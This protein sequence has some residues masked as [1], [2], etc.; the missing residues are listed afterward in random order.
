MKS[1]TII[2]IL[3]I[4]FIF[5]LLMTFFILQANSLSI[6]LSSSNITYDNPRQI[7]EL[8]TLTG[9]KDFKVLQSTTKDGELALVQLERNW[10]GFWEVI[11]VNTPKNDAGQTYVSTA[12]VKGAGTQ[13]YTAT[14]IPEFVY[15]WH[16]VYCGNDALKRI[17]FSEGS[18]PQ[19]ITVNI[20]QIGEFYIIHT[21]SF[22]DPSELG[23]F[24]IPTYLKENG[25]IP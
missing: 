1:R 4:V 10:L 19:N 6:A 17:H 21:I 14:D 15:E 18:L 20:Q 25:F 13:R 3:C 24:S 9:E 12:W 5:F 22:A 8:D 7:V 11:N 16:H 23:S 2:T